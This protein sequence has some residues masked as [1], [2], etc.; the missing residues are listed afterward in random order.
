VIG[1]DLFAGAGGLSHGAALAGI[2]VRL[3]VDIDHHAAFTYARNHRTTE[4]LVTD[5]AKLRPSR[6]TFPSRKLILFGGPPCQGFSTSN[7]R[8][9]SRYNPANWMFRHFIRFARCWAPSYIVLE[10]VRGILDTERGMFAQLIL[11]GLQQLGYTTAV[12]VLNA[13]DYGVPQVRTRVFII[14]ALRG[15][16]IIAPSRVRQP[17][18]TVADAI[19]DL[20]LLPNGANDTS[21]LPYRSQPRSTYARRLRDGRVDCGNH[22]VTSNAPIILERFR[23]IEPG[24]NWRS[25]PVELQGFSTLG[26]GPHT[27]LYHRLLL[28]QPARVIGNFRK[29]MLIHPTQHRGVSVREAARLQSFPDEYEFCGS[30]GFQQQQVGNAVPPLLAA[31]VFRALLREA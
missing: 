25:L 24:G 7:Q 17:P 16:E 6:F 20:P 11:R 23:H 28:D 10:N 1:I 29:N 14:G 13:A 9:R 30:I 5:I 2:D 26:R 4:L 8:T 27:G 3:A 12:H 31:A 21:P 19:G 22:L 18:P 15:R